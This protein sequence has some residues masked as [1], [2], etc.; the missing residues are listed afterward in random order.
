MLKRISIIQLFF[1]WVVIFNLVFPK[2]GIKI[3]DIP[4]TIGI[5]SLLTLLLLG[6]ISSILHFSL[7][8]IK[9]SRISILLSWIPFQIWMLIVIKEN[10]YE[11]LG[12]T[13]SLFLNFLILPWGMLFFNGKNFD[14]IVNVDKLLKVIKYGIWFLIIFG[15]INHGYKIITDNY[16]EVPLLTVN[17]DDA[18]KIYDKNNG[19]GILG[20]LVSTY[21]NGNLFGI[22]MLMFLP[23]FCYIEKKRW[24]QILF[25]F[26]LFLT[27]SRT[28]WLGILFYEIISNVGKKIYAKKVLYLLVVLFIFSF[29][30]VYI[31]EYLG[32]DAEFLLDA[33]LGGRVSTLGDITYE[34]IPLGAFV[35]ITEIVY[36]GVL[37]SFG[38]VGL[39]LF[40]IGFF[41]PLYV[42]CGK[43]KNSLQHNLYL[44]LIMYSFICL[45]D[46]AI[47]LIPVMVLYWGIVLFL[48]SISVEKGC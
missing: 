33:S 26:T 28:I 46:G 12:F 23:L 9:S 43:I 16:I 27:L 34:I 20:K 44:G 3:G 19:R 36:K 18:G 38:I 1:Y 35:T 39:I 21:Q 13:F 32:L 8:K 22:S 5:V 24:K 47:L 10:G 41:S 29:G 45:G 6:S 7:H 11:N 15:L 31:I 30:V 17:Y 40:L 4:I 14:D 25:E 42:Y 37:D 48:T 2:G